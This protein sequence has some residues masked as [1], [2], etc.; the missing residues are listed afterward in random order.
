MAKKC[1][2][3]LLSIVPAHSHGAYT[4]ILNEKNGT[5]NL[6]V[7]IGAFEAQAIAMELEGMKPSRPLTHDLLV[8]TM[9]AYKIDVTEV[10]ITDLQEGIFFSKILCTREG[11][12][13]EI[14]SRTSDAIAI[15]AKFKCPIFCEMHVLEEA[16]YETAEDESGGKEETPGRVIHEELVPISKSHSGYSSHSLEELDSLLEEAIRDEDYAKAAKIRDEIAKRKK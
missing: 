7:L 11:E 14:D 5:R 2:L 6:P 1:E 12:E 10:V 9:Q 16:G 15:A 13:M 8:A 3:Q 4:L